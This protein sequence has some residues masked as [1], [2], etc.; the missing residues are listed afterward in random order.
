VRNCGGGQLIPWFE[1]P[2]DGEFDFLN[3]QAYLSSPPGVGGGGVSI[4]F[5]DR[6]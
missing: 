3:T 2:V 4:T 5:Y 6:Q 1:A